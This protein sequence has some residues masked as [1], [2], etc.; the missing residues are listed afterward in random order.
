M[1]MLPPSPTQPIAL[2]NSEILAGEKNE[3]TPSHVRKEEECY[4][5]IGLTTISVTQDLHSGMALVLNKKKTHPPLEQYITC[6][7]Q[8]SA[9]LSELTRP[10]ACRKT[11]HSM[12][13]WYRTVHIP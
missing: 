7:V 12:G 10:I 8:P 4:G 6:P 3:G 1:A 13:R 5:K 9:Q 2:L 11:Q